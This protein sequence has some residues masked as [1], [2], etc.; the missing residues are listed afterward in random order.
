M[1]TIV[2]FLNCCLLLMFFCGGVLFAEEKSDTGCLVSNKHDDYKCMGMKL[3]GNV[4]RSNNVVTGANLTHGGKTEDIQSDKTHTQWDINLGFHANP[5]NSL[6]LLRKIPSL[7]K[8][9]VFEQLEFDA[10][11]TYGSSY[12]FDNIPNTNELDTTKA[13]RETKLDKTFA[14][15]F[16]V[17][18]F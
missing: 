12:E 16:T 15:R 10:Y 14:L 4:N 7:K 18:L 5:L 9:E 2:Y 8:N 11:F 3:W 6:P 17:P 13:K 1:K